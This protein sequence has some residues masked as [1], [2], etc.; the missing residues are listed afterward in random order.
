MIGGD[1]VRGPLA[2]AV[3]VYGF[4]PPGTALL[5]SGARPGDRI[6]ITNVIGDAGLALADIKGVLELTPREREVVLRQLDYPQPRVIVGTTLRDVASSCIDLSDGLLADLGHVLEASD[7]GARI[8]LDRIPV[9]PIYRN[10]LNTIGGWDL[11]ITSGDDYELC[12]TVPQ[13]K[14]AEL[15]QRLAQCACPVT[16]IGD[17]DAEPGLRVID[18]SGRLYKPKRRGYEHFSA[19]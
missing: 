7:V 18:V 16:H 19:G 14:S 6:Y 4:L 12:F 9:S 2:V 5:R 3:Q 10:H 11:A 1:T 17:I 13:A 8:G 15:E